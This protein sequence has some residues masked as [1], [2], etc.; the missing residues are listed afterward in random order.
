MTCSAHAQQVARVG[1]TPSLSCYDC[2]KRWGFS[3]GLVNTTQ[4][5]RASACASLQTGQTATSG[6]IPSRRLSGAP[7]ENQGSKLP[8]TVPGLVL[9]SSREAS[10]APCGWRH[11]ACS[12]ALGRAPPE[13]L[14]HP[15]RPCSAPRG[16]THLRG[17]SPPPGAT[18]AW[19]VGPEAGFPP[20]SE[21]RGSGLLDDVPSAAPGAASW[22]LGASLTLL[23]A[24]GDSGPVPGFSLDA[25]GPLALVSLGGIRW[26]G[27]TLSGPGMPAS[28]PGKASGWGRTSDPIPEALTGGSL[29]TVSSGRSAFGLSAG[30]QA[31]QTC[32][33]MGRSVSQ[34]RGKEHAGGRLGRHVG[35]R[36]R[37]SSPVTIGGDLADRTTA[38]L[39]HHEKEKWW[40]PRVAMG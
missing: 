22:L 25:P 1:R 26:P 36:P 11:R 39:Q 24:A 33:P 40:P 35:N 21:G 23:G 32:T 37:E 31:G 16:A 34:R 27:G 30:K 5:R 8:E 3:G 19:A 6:Q 9:P 2:S 20:S 18:W 38:Q 29:S 10:P 14:L 15:S 17:A 12:W 13:G 7:G 28:R 4:N